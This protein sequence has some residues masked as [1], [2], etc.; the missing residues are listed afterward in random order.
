MDE[1]TKQRLAILEGKID[2]IYQTT[3]KVRRYFLWTLIITV[4]LVVLPAIGL[5][6]AIPSFLSSYSNLGSVDINNLD[7]NALSQYLQ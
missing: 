5:L 6:F 7:S 3:E 1:E 2:V 4:A